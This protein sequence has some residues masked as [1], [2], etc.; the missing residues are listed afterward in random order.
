MTNGSSA[1]D[2]SEPTSTYDTT[3]PIGP[4]VPNPLV[5]Q[6]N[7]DRIHKDMSPSEV[8][9]ILGKPSGSQTTSIPI[10]GGTETS[11]H[12]DYGDSSVTIVFRNNMV[13][14]KTGRFGDSNP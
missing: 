1:P 12:Y 5:T 7:L 14:F 6:Q 13:K 2:P 11:Y 4:L 9:A 10:F 8:V 3:P